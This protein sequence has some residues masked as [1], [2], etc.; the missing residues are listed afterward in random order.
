MQNLVT[1]SHSVCTQ[2]KGSREIFGTLVPGLFLSVDCS[3]VDDEALCSG[4]SQ[5]ESLSK[6]Q[7][8]KVLKE[9][10]SPQ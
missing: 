9:T 3:I 10:S 6:T 4:P 8:D 5:D 7:S 1:V 2:R